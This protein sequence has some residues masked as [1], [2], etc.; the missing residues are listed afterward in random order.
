MVLEM[1]KLKGEAALSWRSFQGSG[2]YPTSQPAL[3]ND[4]LENVQI[5]K[6]ILELSAV[7]NVRQLF[8]EGPLT[9]TDLIWSQSSSWSW[10][11]LVIQSFSIAYISSTLVHL[12]D[13]G[14]A[15]IC[16]FCCFFSIST[17]GSV[18]HFILVDFRQCRECFAAWWVVSFRASILLPGI[19]V[20]VREWFCGG[21]SFLFYL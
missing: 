9:V 7:L 11:I 14:G 17:S 8:L 15:Y 20:I 19:H 1:S 12:Q 10:K 16:L 2:F 5:H 21:N 3:S 18:Y 13:Q 4:L 6:M